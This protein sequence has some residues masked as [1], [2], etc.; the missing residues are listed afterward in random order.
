MSSAEEDARFADPVYCKQRS[1]LWFLRR[2][3]LICASEVAALL[4][5]CPF[6]QPSDVLDQKLQQ[7]G[8]CASNVPTTN[9]QNGIDSEDSLIQRFMV[10]EPAAELGVVSFSKARLYISG[11]LGASPDAILNMADGS[12]KHSATTSSAAAVTSCKR[13][14]TVHHPGVLLMTGI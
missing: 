12:K 11:F 8:N 13:Q 3:F 4:G 7:A 6:R 10:S 1:A 2:L 14:E 9:Q 5:V